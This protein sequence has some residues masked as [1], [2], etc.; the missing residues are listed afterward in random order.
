[1][2]RD[3]LVALLPVD[4]MAAKTLGWDLPYAPL[5][6]RLREKT[7]GRILI[8]DSQEPPVADQGKPDE[9]TET[10]WKAF[11]QALCE[12]PLFIQYTIEA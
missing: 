3:D 8:S 6:K 9:L 5:L 10:E 7:R 11:K 2:Q 1:M 12:D 4:R